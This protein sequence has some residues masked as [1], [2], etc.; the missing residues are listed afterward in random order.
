MGMVR[1]RGQDVFDREIKKQASEGYPRAGLA[2]APLGQP[3]GQ[4]Q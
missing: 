4:A 1:R 3:T 2:L